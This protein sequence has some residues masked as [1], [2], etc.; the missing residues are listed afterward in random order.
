MK[1]FAFLLLALATQLS[2]IT[3]YS[4]Y[5]KAEKVAREDH[6]PMFLFFTGSDWCGYCMK[7]K[8][9]VL[10]TSAFNK[11]VG[12]KYVFVDID[13]P[14]HKNQSAAL[15]K[16]N[17]KLANKYGITGYPTVILLDDHQK[18]VA[19]MGYEP[20]GPAGYIKKLD[21]LLGSLAQLEEKMDGLAAA[22]ADLPQLYRQAV[23][24][25]RANYADKILAKGLEDPKSTFFLAEKYRD[26]VREGE[27][28]SDEAKALRE[29]LLARDPDNQ[30]GQHITVA[31][32]DFQQSL[33]NESLSVE[34]RAKPLTDY[35]TQHGRD[36]PNSWR[37][38][39]TL[40]Q[41]LLGEGQG[42]E[43]AKYARSGLNAAPE[44]IRPDIERFLA[45]LDLGE[46]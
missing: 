38:Q 29:E 1:K 6:K 41:Y 19:E 21:K 10:D 16:K 33:Q 39:V 35:L 17:Q 14:M 46:T 30:E 27:G 32:L 13:F 3:W 31:V 22:E 8:K 9:E 24:L 45:S 7:L 15:K 25:G 28:H 20:G 44:H 23:E 43:A 5:D 11:A 2:A 42:E 37:V 34:E 4:D 26:L 12:N 40:A 36:D 18:K